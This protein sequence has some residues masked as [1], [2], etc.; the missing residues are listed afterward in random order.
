MKNTKEILLGHEITVHNKRE[1]SLVDITRNMALSVLQWLDVNTTDEVIT[2]CDSESRKRIANREAIEIDH[3]FT[4]M[5]FMD[6][7]K[8]P[9]YIA[10]EDILS[11]NGLD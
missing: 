9:S 5:Y 8:Q 11:W 3:M 4:A 2:R 7:I 6:M 1:Q 10:L